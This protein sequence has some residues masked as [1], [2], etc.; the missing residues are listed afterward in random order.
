MQWTKRH[1][2]HFRTC[3][4][5]PPVF[6]YWLSGSSPWGASL[7]ARTARYTYEYWASGADGLPSTA[8]RWRRGPI[9]NFLLL[10][11]PFRSPTQ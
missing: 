11:W 8:V 9:E 5:P 7:S 3:A 6:C 2:E 4:A 10:A 1:V